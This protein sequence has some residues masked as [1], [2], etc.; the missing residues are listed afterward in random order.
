MRQPTS[1]NGSRFHV[2]TP[3][4]S[5]HVQVQRYEL[6]CIVANRLNFGNLTLREKISKNIEIYICFFRLVRLCV[7]PCALQY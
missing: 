1:R 7:G 5:T 3:P 4:N 2:Q 6:I